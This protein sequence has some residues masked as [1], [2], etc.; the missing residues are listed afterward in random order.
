MPHD[1]DEHDDRGEVDLGAEEAQRR[2]RRPRPAA[3]DS[4]AEAEAPI[5]L[6]PKLDRPA[7]RL[8]R[9]GGRMQR[10]AAQ[11]ALLG[12][13]RVGEIAVAGEQKIVERGVGQQLSIQ[14]MR[15]PRFDGARPY[16][17]A[18]TQ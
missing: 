9:I 8:A 5:M 4:T 16:G 10:A 7:T 6:G 13:G 2:W 11:R 17:K 1:R 3:I 14:R 15:P 12:S 18:R